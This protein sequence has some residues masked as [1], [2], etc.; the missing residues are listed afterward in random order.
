[1]HGLHFYRFLR[2]NSKLFINVGMSIMFNGEKKSA[3]V[4]KYQGRVVQK[5]ISANP[6][7]KF[8]RLFILVYS[9]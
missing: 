3:S 4:I 7:L 9:A 5:A 6:G 2:K 8:N 1:M